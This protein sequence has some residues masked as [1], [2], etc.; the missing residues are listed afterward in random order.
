MKPK[1]STK[2]EGLLARIEAREAAS[3]GKPA[4]SEAKEPEANKPKPCVGLGPNPLD[5]LKCT[6]SVWLLVRTAMNTH[7]TKATRPGIAAAL[8]AKR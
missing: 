4:A 1:L 2:A 8:S 7:F 5:Y 6:T 3:K